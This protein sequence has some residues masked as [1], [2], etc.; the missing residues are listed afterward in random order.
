MKR[1]WQIII[2]VVLMGG[3]AALFPL[4]RSQWISQSL[5]APPGV[6]TKEVSLIRVWLIDDRT[7]AAS[8]LKTQI[9]Q[10]EKQNS[11]YRV[12]LR[13]ALKDELT[14]EGAVLPDLIIFGPGVI[15]EPD[16]W[17][18]V[19]AGDWSQVTEASRAGKYKGEQYAL[20][21]LMGGYALAVDASVG[22]GWQD[23]INSATP[24]KSQ[25]KS[26]ISA[27]YALQSAAGTPL[28]LLSA[29]EGRPTSL[30]EN[31]L[32]SD[33]AQLTQQ[34]VYQDF[35][36][37][38]CHAA[39]LTVSQIRSFYAIV[40]AGK[41]FNI[42]YKIPSIPFT[43]LYLCAG[44]VKGGAESEAAG[45]LAYLLSDDAQQALSEKGLFS[46]NP[47]LTLYD[48]S[49][50]LLQAMEELYKTGLMLPNAFT[51]DQT[52]IENLSYSAWHQKGDYVAMLEPLQ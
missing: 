7:D 12:Y 45:L 36:S 24:A 29:M 28:M 31:A 6:K 43:D 18:T 41:G 37:K 27:T 22:E 52:T 19:L 23:I 11:G 35:T 48:E 17:L 25:G 21:V 13:T 38:R 39:M 26:K 3:M 8:F 4:L 14:A 49:T 46:V 47:D 15:D 50:T 5:K 16:K 1:R 32:S 9:A 10:F 30:S 20:P 40:A 42:V 2:F 44:I 34:R 33:F 51:Y